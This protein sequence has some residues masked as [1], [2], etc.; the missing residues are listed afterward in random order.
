MESS[1]R[2][3]PSIALVLAFVGASMGVVCY[4]FFTY[5]YVLINSLSSALLVL[6]AVLQC[7]MDKTMPHP[8]E[9]MTIRYHNV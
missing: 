1:F 7:E 5:E 6:S 8:V 9:E 3:P 4:I 2:I